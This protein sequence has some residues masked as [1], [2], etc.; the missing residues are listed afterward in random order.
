MVG[1]LTLAAQAEAAPWNQSRFSGVYFPSQAGPK[2]APQVWDAQVTSLKNSRPLIRLDF[3]SE[4]DAR[5]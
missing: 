2:T 3:S 1:L 5:E 4:E